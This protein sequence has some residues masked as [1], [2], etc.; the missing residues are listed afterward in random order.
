MILWIPERQNFGCN[1]GD[2]LGTL[3]PN[4]F[5]YVL[6]N[7]LVH[8]FSKYLLGYHIWQVLCYPVGIQK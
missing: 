6:K 1:M 3:D 5:E 4:D 2:G 7:Y 8:A